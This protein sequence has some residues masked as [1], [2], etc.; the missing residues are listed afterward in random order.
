MG[1]LSHI[2]ARNIHD[3]EFRSKHMEIIA[4]QMEIES[5]YRIPG[6][7]QLRNGLDP[8]LFSSINHVRLHKGKENCRNCGANSYKNNKCEYCGTK[9]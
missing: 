2:L 5:S 8:D 3:L 9:I 1:F 7:N 6:Y 4:A